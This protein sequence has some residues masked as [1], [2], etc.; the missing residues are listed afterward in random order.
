[1]S[2]RDKITGCI[3]GGAIGD[4]MGGPFEGQSQ[5]IEFTLE[6]DWRIS[7]DTQ[8][9]LATCEA[10]CEKG[11][12]SPERIADRFKQWFVERKISGIGS[13]TLKALR[14]LSAGAHWSIAGC[15][16]EYA[17]GNGAAMRIAPLA[18][19]LDPGKDADRM[20]IRDAARITHKNEEAYAGALAAAI[21]VR[22]AFTN[23]WSGKHELL[24]LVGKGLPDCATR[25]RIFSLAELN[26]SKSIPEAAALY[27]ASGYVVESVPLALYAAGFISEFGFERLLEQVVAAGGDTDTNAAITCRETTT[28]I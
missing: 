19:F 11:M 14:D 18:F 23:A 10:L 27:G 7:D 4:A 9:T 13:S 24:G 20:L 22:L 15:S 26:G 3:L 16:G 8:L 1:M 12:A 21:A 28:V 5:P 17:A 25:D 6:H 2:N